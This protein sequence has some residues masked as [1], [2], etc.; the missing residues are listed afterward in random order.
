MVDELEVGL[1]EEVDAAVAL[2]GATTLEDEL[3]DA[4]ELAVLV[5]EV[6]LLLVAP[7]RGRHPH[8]LRVRCQLHVQ[9]PDS[10]DDGYR[11]TGQDN[12]AGLGSG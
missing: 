10:T 12:D 8:C 5:I 2:V 7:A 6:L 3:V 4:E 11:Q 9:H 1:F